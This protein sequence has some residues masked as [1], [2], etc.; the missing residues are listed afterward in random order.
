MSNKDKELEVKDPEL[1]DDSLGARTLPLLPVRDTVRGAC[2]LY[3]LDPLL[4]ANEGKLVAFVPMAQSD[5][6]LEAMRAHPLGRDAVR[7][8]QVGLPDD[9]GS[10][11]VRLRTPLGGYRILDL[12]YA[13]PLPRIC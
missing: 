9:D 6:A 12:P 10:G 3:G 7:I 1:R 11:L 2:E 13:E 5:V 4:L 8:G